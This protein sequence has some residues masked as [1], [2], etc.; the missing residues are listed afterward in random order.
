MPTSRIDAFGLEYQGDRGHKHFPRLASL[1]KAEV[2]Q[3][4]EVGSWAGTS[5]IAWDKAFEG[6][7]RFTV[8]DTWAPY[9]PNGVSWM[10]DVM[11]RVA[12]SGEIYERF[13]TNIIKQNMRDR[14]R[15]LVDDS[16]Q[17]LPWLIETM[18]RFDLIYIDGDHRYDHAA[19]DILNGK[20]L[21]NA[22]GIL[23]GDDLEA[24]L[25]ELDDLDAHKVAIEAGVDFLVHKNHRGRDTNG[26]PYSGHH[27]G[28]TQAVADAFGD[29]VSCVDCLWAMRLTDHGWVKGL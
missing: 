15:I 17:A 21:V 3:V 26:T 12:E 22:G 13:I 9:W 29:G 8:V 25:F 4:L 27:P 5:L 24:Q 20:R 10:G 23:C 7:A 2:P 14:V 28:V 6:R 18:D 19:S 16:R 1:I 11:N